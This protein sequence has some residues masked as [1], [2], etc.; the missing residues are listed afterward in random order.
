[1]EL[2]NKVDNTKSAILLKPKN[3]IN[4][5]RITE[6]SIEKLKDSFVKFVE[7]H[8]SIRNEIKQRNKSADIKVCKNEVDYYTIIIID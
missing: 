4:A 7:R 5:S 8:Q 3:S 1:M 6:E 2:T